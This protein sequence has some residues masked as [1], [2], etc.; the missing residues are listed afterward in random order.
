[1]QVETKTGCIKNKCSKFGR[2]YTSQGMHMECR[3]EVGQVASI[4]GKFAGIL[5]V[6]VK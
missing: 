3:Q 2:D 4:T 6:G 1:M 5:S